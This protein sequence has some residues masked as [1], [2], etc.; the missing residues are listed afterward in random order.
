MLFDSRVT[1]LAEAFGPAL[2]LARGD[3]RRSL[4]A[5]NWFRPVRSRGREP[6]RRRL[7]GSSAG[8]R[9]TERVACRDRAAIRRQFLTRLRAEVISQGG[10]WARLAP[11]PHP[12]RSAFN[13][14]IDL[15][16]PAPD[17]YARF[18]RARRPLD[19]CTTHFVCT[20][21]YSEFGSIMAELKR[22]DTQSH[23][24][25]HFVYR[26]EATNERNL[27]RAHEA[28]WRT[29][30]S[31]P[32]ASPLPAGAG[33]RDWTSVL[34]RLG[35]LYSS[36]F[37]LGFDDVPFFPWVGGRFST[38]LQVPIH[39]VCEGLFLEAGH[40]RAGADF[41]LPARCRTFADR[42]RRA[43]LRL[44]PSRGPPGPFPPGRY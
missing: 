28:R 6:R 21:A 29:R 1:V 33:M 35:Y 43:G 37:H 8:T 5:R 14:R 22:L 12:Y 38:V 42:S 36:D 2:A 15:D 11:F 4:P 41:I 30:A 39:P 26:D 25:F 32:P 40:R 7:P 23:G 20:H 18:A 13:L 44:R 9:L 31:R 3:R 34:E 19:D 24:H 10:V 27:T 17:D 16:E